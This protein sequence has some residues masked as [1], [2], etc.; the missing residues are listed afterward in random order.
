MQGRPTR[1]EILAA[2]GV[3]MTAPAAAQAAAQTPAPRKRERPL[4]ILMIVS[5][6][7]RE[8]LPP[9]LPLP[10]HEWL[11]RRGVSFAKH[12]V[13]TSPCGP[14]RAVIYTGQHTQRTGVYVNPN[15]PP[16]PQLKPE[17]PTIGHMLRQAGYYTAYKGKWH[18]S[19]IAEG[20]RHGPAEGIWPNASASLEPYGF[21]NYNFDGEREGLTW[22]GFMDDGVTAADAVNQLRAFKDGASGGKPWFM[23]VNFINP[24]DIMFFDA[25]GKAET[26]RARPNLI[27]PLM[28]APG[29]PVYDA[30]W[31]LPLPRS[32]YA[33]DLA[34]KP[35]SHA[36]INAASWAFYGELPR[37]DE[38]SWKRFQNYYFNCIRDMDRHAMTVLNALEQTGQ[39][40]DTIV[41][42][43]SDHGERAGAHGMRQKAGTIYHE[44]IQVPLIIAHPDLPGGGRTEALSTTLDLAPTILGLAGLS[45]SERAERHP[46]LKGHDL[47]PALSGGR[48]GRDKVGA[49]LNYACRYGWNAPDVASDQENAKPLREPDLSLRRLFRGVH[50]GRFKFARYFAPAQHHEPKTWDVLTAHNDLELYDTRTD[51]DEIRNLAADPRFKREILRLNAMTN[52]LVRAEVGRDDGSEYPGPTEQYNTLKI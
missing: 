24:H 41:I 28:G 27:S 16:Y 8:A 20:E 33:D 9:A 13:N 31:N 21:A 38:A 49:L 2:G 3:A 43:T 4:N 51:P 7:E 42:F 50:D 34:A 5:D 39:L 15:T 14:S 37:V 18:V 12:N 26:T 52:A 25:T 48:T 29:D 44:D 45:D 11:R 35:P 17:T 19:N 36:A 10:A 40:Q 22:Q 46:Q 30:E 23:A 6:Q 32:F 47:T 1:R